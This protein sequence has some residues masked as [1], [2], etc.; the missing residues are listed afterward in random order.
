MQSPDIEFIFPI[1]F[2]S[3]LKSIRGNSWKSLVEDS[4]EKNMI[5]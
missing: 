2:L 4:F 3:E 1:R 5:Y